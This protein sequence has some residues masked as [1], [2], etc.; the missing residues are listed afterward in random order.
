MS[1]I[2]CRYSIIFQRITFFVIIALIGVAPSYAYDVE[3][4]GIYYNLD[5][6]SRTAEVTYKYS[7][8]K[9]SY[10]GNVII[11]HKIVYEGTT[12]DIKHIGMGA[13]NSCSSPLSVTI[14][15]SV[16]SIGEQA[17]SGQFGRDGDRP[18]YRGS[19]GSCSRA[20]LS[21][22][23]HGPEGYLRSGKKDADHAKG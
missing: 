3:I 15:N 20:V 2:W 17:F 21:H 23:Q 14:P 12:F 10:T 7:D 18:E 13:F 8:G 6:N 22:G 11:P 5:K 4:D 9:S 19:G 16:I 1:S